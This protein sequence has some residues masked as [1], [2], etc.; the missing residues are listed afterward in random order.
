MS[1]AIGQSLPFG[2]AVAL[3]AGAII[4][5]V[6]MLLTARGRITG[7]SFLLG[8]SLGI[9][10]VGAILLAIA[11]PSRASDHDQPAAWVSALKLILG[12]LL[13]A[14]AVQ[15]WRARPA[16]GKA[17]ATPKRTGTLDGFTP[18]KGART[19]VALVVIAVKN[20]LLMIGPLRLRPRGAPGRE[21]D[22]R[23]DGVHAERINRGC[24]ASVV[25]FAMGTGATGALERLRDWMARNNGATVAAI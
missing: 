16:E 23:L 19:G 14:A 4:V 18:F 11:S 2:I 3:R 15:Q 25:Y 7:R 12:I 6:L 13:P 9:A 17:L 20:L 24:R 1:I 8:R 5:K 10:G 21:A 22:H